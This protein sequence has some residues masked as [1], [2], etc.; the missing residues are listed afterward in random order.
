M[1]DK[2]LIANCGDIPFDTRPAGALYV[3]NGV[4]KF[5]HDKTFNAV[6]RIY[7]K[8]VNLIIVERFALTSWTPPAAIE[9]DWEDPTYFT[10][11]R[12]YVETIHNPTQSK[13]SLPGVPV[14]I[15]FFIGAC[16][17]WMY[18]PQNWEKAR[19]L[20]RTMFATFKDLPYVR[21]CPGREM[22]TKLF[23]DNTYI[24]QG[25]IQAF[26]DQVVYPEF[27]AAG[28][29]L[30]AYGACYT[31]TNPPWMGDLEQQK[32]LYD[33]LAGEPAALS[34]WRKVHNVTDE[35]STSLIE[36][37]DFWF[38]NMNPNLPAQIR[39]IFSVDGS[40]GGTSEIDFITLPNGQIQRRPSGDQMKS[41]IR[42]IIK[43]SSCV[44]LPDGSPKIGFEYMS[45][46]M[47]L[48]VV[49]AQ[50]ESIHEV[51]QEL[52]ISQENYGKYP[53]DWVEP[54]IVVPPGPVIDVP[55]VKPPAITWQGWLGLAVI[56]VA[57]V[58]LIIFL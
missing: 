20:I 57:V 55:T 15:S 32:G 17:Y 14:V 49:E 12:Q 19:T 6:R 22:N 8:G 54:V 3:E 35:N 21:F 34:V 16:E 53:N 38:R 5:D 44:T 2:I 13:T 25:M 56:V 36:T 10:L 23:P 27:E 47:T 7:N 30:F 40:W 58:L 43:N 33:G 39:A 9:F 28:Q 26:M 42:Y 51:L 46:A 29:T 52:G 24:N 11:L 45:K 41:A 31:T 1:K 50:L 37:I 18:L 48:D 4:V